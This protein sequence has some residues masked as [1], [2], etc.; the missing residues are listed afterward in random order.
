MVLQVRPTS[1]RF[2][3]NSLYTPM[4]YTPLHSI[5]S[6]CHPSGSCFGRAYDQTRFDTGM[7]VKL[8]KTCQP[9]IFDH[10]RKRVQA[11]LMAVWENLWGD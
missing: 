5:S 11:D 4:D 3:A 2:P 9:T 8:L 1:T 6:V 7:W 10:R